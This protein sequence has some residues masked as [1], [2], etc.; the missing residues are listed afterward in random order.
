MSSI[1]LSPASTSDA[2]DLADLFIDAFPDKFGPIL[3]HHAGPLFQE[4]FEIDPAEFTA[5]TIIARVDDQP[6]GFIQFG[7]KRSPFT[8]RAGL[9][10]AKCRKRFG[11]PSSLAR[12]LKLIILEME[13]PLR[14]GELYIKTIGVASRFRGRGIGTK[15]VEKAEERARSQGHYSMS[16]LV[17]SDNRGAIKLYQRLGFELGRLHRSHILRWALKRSGYHKMFKRLVTARRRDR[18]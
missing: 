11:L 2:A 16:L 7:G 4:L 9:V 14:R 18:Y 5:D 12:Y 15:L 3:E 10:I 6:A 17:M 13:P 1:E 8:T